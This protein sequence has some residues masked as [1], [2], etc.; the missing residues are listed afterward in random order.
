MVLHLDHSNQSDCREEDIVVEAKEGG[1][2][3]K[4]NGRRMRNFGEPEKII[5][6]MLEMRGKTRCP[7]GEEE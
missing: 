3:R 2:G 5:R 6:E 7:G 4:K 1:A